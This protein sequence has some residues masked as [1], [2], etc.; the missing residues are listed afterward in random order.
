MWV[1]NVWC[2]LWETS[3]GTVCM[4][5]NGDVPWWKKRGEIEK[6]RGMEECAWGRLHRERNVSQHLI[7][8]KEFCHSHSCPVWFWN[9]G[10]TH[11]PSRDPLSRKHA[12]ARKPLSLA[13]QAH[14]CAAITPQRKKKKST[15]I[16][17]HPIHHILAITL[18][19]K[20]WN[21]LPA[22]VLSQQVLLTPQV[23]NGLTHVGN[24]YVP[25]IQLEKVAHT[26]QKQWD[27]G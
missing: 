20:N 24:Q 27:F 3:L 12:T 21:H 19:L 7:S 15:N 1:P 16:L 23:L 2:L 26:L 22:G 6:W 14:M 25:D 13:I 8:W 17:R 4:R 18:G 11:K 5:W 10:R 9:S